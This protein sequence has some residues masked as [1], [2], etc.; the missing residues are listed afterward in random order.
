M[1]DDL[2]LDRLE[3]QGVAAGLVAV[4]QLQLGGHAHA[5]V[6][7]LLLEALDHRLEA[8]AHAGMTCQPA[9][10]LRDLP[11][12]LLALQVEHRVGVVGFELGDL[13]ADHG[14]PDSCDAIDHDVFLHSV[15]DLHAAFPY[16]RSIFSVLAS[17]ILETR[18]LL[19]CSSRRV[20]ARQKADDTVK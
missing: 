5:D 1:L 16:S 4:A 15:G 8:R 11:V 9:I 13:R 2:V 12:Q 7:V 17:L 10:V 18:R 19:S 6:R 14:A 20:L 3:A